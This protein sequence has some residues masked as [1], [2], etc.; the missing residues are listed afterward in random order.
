MNKISSFKKEKVFGKVKIL[1]PTKK[2]TNLSAKNIK[3]S[4]YDYGVK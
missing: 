2:K 1:F 4:W 3:F